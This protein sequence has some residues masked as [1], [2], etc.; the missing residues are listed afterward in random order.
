M[1][2]ATQFTPSRT[3]TSAVGLTDGDAFGVAGNTQIQSELEVDAPEGNQAFLMEDTDGW[4]TM[5]FDYVDL[6][7]TTSPMVSLKYFVGETGYE[8]G[9]GGNDRFFVGVLID[10]CAQATTVTLID[11]DGG[12]SGG[13]G[14]LDMDD[15]I[16]A[17][18]EDAWTTL[19]ANLSPYV[20]CRAQLIIEFDSNSS[21]EELGIDDI[22][23]TEGTRQAFC[24]DSDNDGV[25]DVLDPCP[26]DNPND[27]D[28]DGVCDSDDICEGFDG[29]G[30]SDG[31]G[32]CDNLDPCTGPDNVDADF[33][34]ICDSIDPCFGNNASGDADGDGICDDRDLCFGADNVD[35][36]F[37]GVCDS[38][39]LCAGNDSFGDSDGDGVCD[40]FDPCPF[41][42][43][44]DSD[45]D[46][47]CDSNDICEG[48]DGS[49]DSDGDG[50]CDNLD[51]CTGPDNVDADND[52][53]CDSFDPCFGDNAS[54]DA[55]G[56][57][58]CDNL[59]SCFGSDNVD[60]DNDGVCD[61]N[62]I[63]NGD[64]ASGDTDGDGVCDNLD[65]CPLDPLNDSDSDGVCDS[66]DLC[67]GFDPSGDTDGDGVC[68]NLD[69]C[70]LDP[71]NTN[72][73]DCG[74]A[75]FGI[76][77]PGTFTGNSSSFPDRCE[78]GSPDVTYRVVIPYADDW[79]FSLCGSSFDTELSLGY[80]CC[81]AL[82]G[83]NDN[84]CG[85]QSQFTVTNL[86]PGPYFLTISGANAGEMGTY[87]LLISPSD[88][89]IGETTPPTLSCP[90]TQVENLNANC[91]FSLPDY[92]ALATVTDECGRKH[93]HLLKVLLLELRSQTILPLL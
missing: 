75:D 27:S 76:T 89:C 22:A 1:G 79:T 54:G 18:I 36:D 81:T 82:L 42:D 24:P 48:F 37:D 5:F 3:G 53:I 20:G 87:T 25:C 8:S 91:E 17:V 58:I 69:G 62:D 7:G 49:G 93:L 71:N 60:S 72:I 86:Q 12:G 92:T 70:P 55:D 64:D 68:D 9:N 66:D 6:T 84:F 83:N 88:P 45:G 23:F 65:P 11:T 85:N 41:D 39:D 50:L 74:C 43:P 73:A 35:S 46:G 13:G 56:D 21:S 33:D 38:N 15:G 4:V 90:T 78:N 19:S 34:G 28:G 44:N 32:I 67:N 2:F 40:D 26:L 10:N 51:P 16:N 30:D 29:S 63:C 61:A 47:V 14:G 80:S 77:A 31:D 59:D 52:G 57:G